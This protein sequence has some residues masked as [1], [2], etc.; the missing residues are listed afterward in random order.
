MVCDRRESKCGHM[1]FAVPN[2]QLSRGPKANVCDSKSGCATTECHCSALVRG[3][4]ELGKCHAA[5]GRFH[6][7]RLVGPALGPGKHD[8]FVEALNLAAAQDAV[9]RQHT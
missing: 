2:A 9:R 4:P 6:R 1:R 8:G 3:K 5:G 7:E